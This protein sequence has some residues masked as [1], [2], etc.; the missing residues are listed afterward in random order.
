MRARIARIAAISAVLISGLAIAAF[1]DG[2]KTI[3]SIQGPLVNAVAK[4]TQLDK[5][6][7]AL[8]STQEAVH[9]TIT[10]TTGVTINHDYVNVSVGDAD[11]PVDPFEVDN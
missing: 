8:H 7:D 3:L 4:A 6:G 9:S 11:I 1:A 2:N 10:A 5:V